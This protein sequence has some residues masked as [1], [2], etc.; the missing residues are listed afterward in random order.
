MQAH[1][2]GEVDT[3]CTFLLRV[4][5]ETLVPIFIWNQF[6]FERPR[7][8]DKFAPFFPRQGVDLHAVLFERTRRGLMVWQTVVYAT[9]FR[10]R[11]GGKTTSEAA[12]LNIDAVVRFPECCTWARFGDNATAYYRISIPQIP[13]Y[14]LRPSKRYCCRK[15]FKLVYVGAR[16][17]ARYLVSR[18]TGVNIVNSY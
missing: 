17:Y 12:W 4:H 14:F 15:R 13:R 5:S 11:I 3:L 1:T 6:I 18:I 7:A 16:H 9:H 8:N 2:T 10:M